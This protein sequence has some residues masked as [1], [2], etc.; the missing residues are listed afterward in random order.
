MQIPSSYFK[1]PK[2]INKKKRTPTVP[3]YLNKQIQIAMFGK[4][5][6]GQFS[7]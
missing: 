7:F 1:F 4:F 3:R 6:V 2:E 5:Q